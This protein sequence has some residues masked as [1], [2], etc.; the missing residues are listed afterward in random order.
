MWCE[1]NQRFLINFLL[2]K[3]NIFKGCPPIAFYTFD[4]LERGLKLACDSFCTNETEILPDENKIII[5]RLFLWYGT[6]FVENPDENIMEY[7]S[8][9]FMT[10]NENRQKFDQLKSTSNKITIEYSAYNWELNNKI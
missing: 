4:N 10:D 5:S 7:I 8:S 3:K 6:D 9:N 2:F 1:S